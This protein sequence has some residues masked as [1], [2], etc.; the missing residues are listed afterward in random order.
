MNSRHVPSLV[1]QAK[2]VATSSHTN[3]IYLSTPE[4]HKRMK[5]LH[6]EN[7]LARLKLERLTAKRKPLRA[8]VF[9]W[10]MTSQ[11]IYIKSW[12]KKRK[13]WMVLSLDPF[14]SSSGV[15]KKRQLASKTSEECAG[16]RR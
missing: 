15:S 14:A 7:R 1:E 13:Q 2:R 16:I 11:M 12:K 9:H 10:M 8:K 5:S 3:Y 6:H 4:K